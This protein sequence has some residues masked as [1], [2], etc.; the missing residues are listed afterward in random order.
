MGRCRARGSPWVLI[1]LLTD[2][3]AQGTFDS[4]VST[5]LSGNSKFGGPVL[6]GTKVVFA[7]FNQQL[8]GVYDVG[9]STFDASISTGTLTTN[10]KFSGGAAVG[11]TVVFAPFNANWV[12]VYDVTAGTFD[13]SLSSGTV[14]DDGNANNKWNGAAVL[15]TK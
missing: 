5:G 11:N 1:L 10:A 13:A 7:P 3:A 8:V 15:G 9:T 4:S 6:V 14:R 12:G 2:A